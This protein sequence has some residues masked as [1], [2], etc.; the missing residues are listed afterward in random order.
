M[1]QRFLIGYLNGGS[2][3][4]PPIQYWKF[5]TVSQAGRHQSVRVRIE[6]P[7]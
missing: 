4:P 7:E 6:Q 2:L 1:P 3:G 5:W